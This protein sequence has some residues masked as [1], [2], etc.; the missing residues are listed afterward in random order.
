MNIQE[1]AE[2]IDCCPD[3]IRFMSFSK[4]HEERLKIVLDKWRKA[5]RPKLETLTQKEKK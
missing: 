3:A 4:K 2:W 5:G 1:F